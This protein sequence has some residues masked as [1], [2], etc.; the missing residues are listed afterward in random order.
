MIAVYG[1]IHP[2]KSDRIELDDFDALGADEFQMAF[3]QWLVVGPV[4]E[5]IKHGADFNPFLDLLCQKAEQGIG[6]GVVAEVE[7]FQMDM[8]PGMAD[9]LEE[10]NE[11][12]MTGHQ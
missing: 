11:L 2:G 5:S 10:V 1:M 9:I 7:V 4:A 12:V 6:Y 8:V 3:F